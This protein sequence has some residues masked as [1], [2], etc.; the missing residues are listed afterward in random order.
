MTSL[1]I[2]FLRCISQILDQAREIRIGRCNAAQLLGVP[3]RRDEIS[4]IAI[5]GEGVY[6]GQPDGASNSR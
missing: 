4:G 2:R 3:E 5:E 1:R 6:R